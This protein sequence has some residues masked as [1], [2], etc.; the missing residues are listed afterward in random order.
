[1]NLKKWVQ[2]SS[3]V[4]GENLLLK[5][6]VVVW[7]IALVVMGFRVERAVNMQRTIIMP[8][9]LGQKVEVGSADASDEY[10]EHYARYALNLALN[11]TPATVRGQFDRLLLLYAPETYPK[12]QTALYELASAIEK[13]RNT[14]AFYVTSIVVFRD[15]EEVEIAGLRRQFIEDVKAGEQ[16]KTY[17]MKYRVI[18]GRMQIVELAEKPEGERR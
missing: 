8:P 13:A 16:R 3:N 1:M 7:G 17:V 9:G 5:F 2:R 11:Y 14:N 6:V 18:N 10:I 4:F 12:A 15:K